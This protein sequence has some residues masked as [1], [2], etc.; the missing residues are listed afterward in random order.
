MT[1]RRRLRSREPSTTV[2]AELGGVDGVAAVVED[3]YR[4]L[5]ADPEVAPWFDDVDVARVRA[6][7]TDF[8][9]AVVDGP[10]AWA[11]PALWAVHAPLAVTDAAFDAT[12]SHLLDALADRSLPPELLDSVLD[13]VAPLRPAVVT[14]R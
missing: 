7:M 11:G 1:V 3:L 10:A 9:V 14:R 8:L 5:L 2:L 12:A 13:R 4:R 6:H